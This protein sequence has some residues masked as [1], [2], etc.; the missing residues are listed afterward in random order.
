M[1]QH[2]PGQERHNHD[3]HKPRDNRFYFLHSRNHGTEKLVNDGSTGLPA[4]QNSGETTR[5]RAFL[6][7]PLAKIKKPALEPGN[8][9]KYTT[10]ALLEVHPHF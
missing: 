3:C 5:R 7:P 8:G 10:D 9:V 6:F 4:Q 2:R 1:G